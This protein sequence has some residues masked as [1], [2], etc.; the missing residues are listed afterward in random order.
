VEV[1]A[2]VRSFTFRAPDG[3][4]A[5]I[6]VE[7]DEGSE[8]A[9]AV[10]PLG[11]VERGESL[12]LQGRWVDDPRFGRQLRVDG[13]LP[14]APESRAGLARFL[15]SG[16]VEGLGPELAQRLV[17]KFGLDTLDVL[18]HHPHRVTEVE[19][20]GP[21]RARKIAAA[22]AEQRE[23]RALMVH[24]RG[25]GIGAALAS[26]VARRFGSRALEVCRKDPYRLAL[27][28]PGVGFS[29]A[30]R[31]ARAEGLPPD[32]PTR[33]AAGAHHFLAEAAEAGHVCRPRDALIEDTAARLSAE[34]EAVASALELLVGEGRLVLDGEP[35]PE[36]RAYLPKLHRA[37]TLAAQHVAAR[38]AT[39]PPPLRAPLDR[40]LATYEAR[41]KIRLAE[42][43][44]AAL[45][46]AAARPLLVIT[47]GPGTGKT[48]LV[49]A[50]LALYAAD[51][52]DVKLAAP[53]GRAAKRLE[54]AT[55]GTAMTLH[56][57][58]EVDP[59][60]GRFQRSASAPLEADVVV[61][62]EVSMVD[63]PLLA[64]LLDALPPAA[65]LVLVGDAHQLPS[66][67]PGR[68]LADLLDAGVPAVT[69]TEVFRQAEQSL[70]VR[71]AHRIDHGEA[72]ERPPPEA[73]E[74]AD[75]YVIERPHPEAALAT[76]LELVAERIPRR[77]GIE[78]VDGVQV[79]T[80]MNKGPLGGRALNEALQR[81]LNPGAGG[82]E[83]AEQVLRPGDKVM[84]TKNDY[85][86]G[87]LNGE[88]GRV[89]AVDPKAGRVRVRF[90]DD[91]VRYE[92][93]DL[94]HLQLAY[95]CSIHKAQGSE[96][97]AV[98]L[99]L[100]DPHAIMLDRQLVYTGVTRARRLLVVV[101]SPRALGLARRPPREGARGSALTR[102]I[103][104]PTASR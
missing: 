55:R 86:L 14:A 59:K 60:T 87:V 29:T 100:G 9:T 13:W 6:K 66:V 65:R 43:Q 58:L 31:L 95:A 18:D 44:R 102:R 22:W 34:P 92:R 40:V 4:F 2:V 79:L 94:E 98:V 17:D 62:D 76:V 53:T 99:V 104:L 96:Y 47:G 3:D 64:S 35:G 15:G 48:T 56:R 83:R 63:L 45:R 75:F 91:E 54:E 10:G 90:E 12:R 103:G 8:L 78:P 50:L 24:L 85:E 77:F 28:V 101:A 21:I 30:D 61:V 26:R 74:L 88:M 70:I 16:T 46:D 52:L 7:L 1:D 42:A 27:E 41:E 25:H 19:G 89:E 39:A 84:Q 23:T 73:R 72:F 33:L 82:L 67:G 20:I 68:V 38:L 49:K 57:L 37:E 11:A 93:K 5:V 97:P 71:N 69:L 81:R 51:R 36:V 32:H 80:P